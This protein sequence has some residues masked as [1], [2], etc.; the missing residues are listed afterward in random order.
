MSLDAALPLSRGGRAVTRV[1]CFPEG[2]L[3][4]APSSGTARCSAVRGGGRFTI[5]R[6]GPGAQPFWESQTARVGLLIV[7]R[8]EGGIWCLRIWAL[9]GSILRRD[10]PGGLEGFPRIAVVVRVLAGRGLT[11]IGIRVLSEENPSL[12][13]YSIQL[14]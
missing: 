8:V 1:P 13:F 4:K 2:L 6:H 7:W 11:L 5:T 3:L 14:Y 9:W 12:T 10:G